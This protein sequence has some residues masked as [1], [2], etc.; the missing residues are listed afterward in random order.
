MV[1]QIR[2]KMI[3]ERLRSVVKNVCLG[4]RL[5]NKKIQ[6]RLFLLSKVSMHVMTK[7]SVYLQ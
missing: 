5:Q 1:R 3:Y 2:N 4:E 7:V 6:Q